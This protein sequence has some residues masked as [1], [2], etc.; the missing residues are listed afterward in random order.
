MDR[1]VVERVLLGEQV[2]AFPDGAI[3][4]PYRLVSGLRPSLQELVQIPRLPQSLVALFQA[5]P[6]EGA[7]ATGACELAE[8]RL[9][10]GPVPELVE[11]ADGDLLA[12]CY[13]LES[14]EGELPQDCVPGLVGVVQTGVVDTRGYQ[15]KT[16]DFFSGSPQAVAAKDVPGW[17]FGPEHVQAGQVEVGRLLGWRKVV[18]PT[19]DL[20]LDVLDL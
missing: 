1:V 3:P 15:V 6:L 4:P 2:G 18:D 20:G 10:S 16:V 17:I 19:D 14:V 13:V 5:L 11:V 9:A 8:S 12:L 7:Q